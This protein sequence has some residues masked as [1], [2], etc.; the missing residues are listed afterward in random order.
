MRL[1]C[2]G[3]RDSKAKGKSLKYSKYFDVVFN[4]YT[5]FAENVFEASL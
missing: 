2:Q 5:V 4:I 1:R 3:N